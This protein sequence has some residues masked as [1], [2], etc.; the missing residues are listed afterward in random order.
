ML[1]GE[2]IYLRS[3]EAGDLEQLRNWRNLP[4]FKRNFR[5]YRELSR[6]MQNNW[7]ERIVNGDRNTIMFA[8]CMRETNELL[9]C[10][11]LCYINW[12][13]RSADLSLYIGYQEAYIDDEG[14]AKEACNLL[15][16][17]GFS[18]LNLHKIWTE[19]YEYDAMKIEFYMST[20]GF[21]KDGILRDNHFM[22]GKWWGSWMLSLLENEFV[23]R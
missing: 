3:V 22:D 23:A 4:Q 13:Q 12:V 2:K 18:E 6:T 10:C 14:I 15:F 11:G 21:K 17:Y 5:E 16:G 7:F 9:G 19:L 1:I 20:F 8:I